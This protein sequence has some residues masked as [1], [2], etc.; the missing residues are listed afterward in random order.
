MISDQYLGS[1]LLED[2]GWDNIIFSLDYAN[3]GVLSSD[4]SLDSPD[5]HHIKALL[6]A[7]IWIMPRN[8]CVNYEALLLI[9]G[10]SGV[11][12]SERMSEEQ[13]ESVCK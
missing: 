3:I 13:M 10:C 12:P 7:F 6:A 11:S 8:V 9:G 4:L 1:H 5:K 2:I